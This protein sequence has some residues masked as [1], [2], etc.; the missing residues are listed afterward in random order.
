MNH[1]STAPPPAWG[2]SEKWLLGLLLLFLALRLIYAL[3]GYPPSVTSID[4]LVYT[5][6]AVNYVN[7]G[8]F[9]APGLARQL[10]A[11]GVP[12]LDRH[13]FLNVPLAAY[14]RVAIFEAAGTSTAARRLADWLFLLLAAGSLLLM[15][16]RWATPS[17]ALLAA[18]VFVTNRVAESDIGR[19]DVLALAFGLLALWWSTQPGVGH[20]RPGGRAY[21][22]GLLI[23]LSGMAHQFGGVFWAVIVITWQISALESPRH[24]GRLLVWLTLFGLGGLTASLLWLPQILAA[25][26]AWQQQFSFMLELKHHLSRDFGQLAIRLITLTVG[27]NP[28]VPLVIIAGLLAAGWKRLQYPRRWKTL[29]A[30]GLL[31]FIW[32]CRSFE[33]YTIAY[34]VHFLA[35]ICLLFALAFDE[36]KGWA[37]PRMSPRWAGRLRFAAAAAVIAPGLIMTYI[38]LAENFGLP[39]RATQEK[40]AGLILQQVQPGDRVLAG[41]GYYYQVPGHNK[42]LW[43]WGEKLD[44]RDYNLVVAPYPTAADFPGPD[45]N[46]HEQWCQIFTAEQGAAF[47]RDFELVA[48]VPDQWIQTTRYPTGYKPH[49]TGC[50]IYRN[51]RPR[52]AQSGNGAGPAAQAGQQF[53]LALE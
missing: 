24:L 9:A 14:L 46:I 53:G 13:Y 52:P 23:G 34:S 17:S 6:P 30:G 28:A 31:L 42:S 18:L 38:P 35:V 3:Q 48:S 44:L 26:A 50:Y 10:E 21:G 45:R 43:F 7:S 37:Q 33:P 16:R 22:A 47:Q 32:T 29:A 5:E 11:K 12:G 51:I 27:K 36:L 41:S 49:I 1:P 15:M 39:Y 19:P 8:H 2:T 40:I 25:P 20:E 4:E